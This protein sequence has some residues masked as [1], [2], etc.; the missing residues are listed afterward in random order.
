MVVLIIEHE[1]P[2]DERVHDKRQAG[3]F[4]PDIAEQFLDGGD[5]SA[6]ITAQ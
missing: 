5:V 3:T 2:G 6:S 4:M 1:R